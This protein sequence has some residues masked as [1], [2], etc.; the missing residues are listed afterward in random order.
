MVSKV[1]PTQWAHAY[2]APWL[3]PK[4]IEISQREITEAVFSVMD[5]DGLLK[6]YCFAFFIDGLDEFQSTVRDDH[7]DLVK[8]L[9]NWAASTSGNIKIC[10]SSREH[11]V[12]MDGFTSALRIRL[13]VLTRQDMDTYI[14]DKA[15]HASSQEG[16]ESLVTLIMNKAHG[17]FLW[18][19]LVVKSL[20][21]G[22]ENG[23]SC[24]HLTREADVLPEQMEKLYSHILNSMGGLSRRRAFQ[25][26]SR[27]MELKKYDDYSMSLLAYSFLE[28]YE[29]GNNS[30]IHGNDVFPMSSL[31]GDRGKERVRS[32]SRRL[33]GWCKG[34]VEPY[35]MENMVE[36]QEYENPCAVAWKDWAM[37][38]DFAHRSVLGFLELGRVV[39]DFQLV[40][41]GFDHADAI[42]NL[43]VSDILF[44]NTKS[45][46]TTHRSGSST[47]VLLGILEHYNINH[48]PYTYLERL[49]AL[50]IAGKHKESIFYSIEPMVLWRQREGLKTSGCVAMFVGDA[51][52]ELITSG[53]A[54]PEDEKRMLRSFFVSDPL[55][56][57]TW[58]GLCDYPLW[59]ISNNSELSK[60]SEIIA[61]LA[62]CCLVNGA[63]CW[64]RSNYQSSHVLETLLERGWL[65][66]D[67][68]TN[69]R[70]SDIIIPGPPHEHGDM[71]GFTLWQTF[72]V[73]TL[74][75]WYSWKEDKEQHTR[76]VRYQGRLFELFLRFR[77]DTELSFT[78]YLDR[79]TRGNSRWL[80]VEPESWPDNEIDLTSEDG[81]TPS[82]Q[83]SLREFVK[84]SPFDNK[85]IILQMLDEQSKLSTDIQTN[86]SSAKASIIRSGGCIGDEIALEGEEDPVDNASRR[87][88][89]QP[90]EDIGSPPASRWV[91]AL[92][93]NEFFR[94]S[95]A[96]LTGKS[97]SRGV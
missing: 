91:A 72:L 38:L 61:L 70:P 59:C 14:R 89:L 93:R 2:S 83:I 67:T 69:Y 95:M 58:L 52:R 13:H 76:A 50:L 74:S 47:A 45:L 22:L 17:V 15:E 34:L 28:D 12:F 26:F 40:L 39:L 48:E 55:H 53:V 29:N 49:R 37:E 42:L 73:Q 9:C 16:F 84:L 1:W 80:D 18:V 4:D 43:I 32:T 30:F 60:Q 31:T 75:E 63:R 62:S 66:P 88:T 8:L 78:I 57:L 64:G 97:L 10:V 71:S 85:D 6:N 41:R 56:V 27:V 23:M 36:V 54:S 96:A 20:R 94:L 24:T 87:V 82:L 33:A 46:Y 25:T 68:V 79:T 19:A 86:S 3:V 51:P 35:T 7:R 44:E 11:P 81:T 65:S 92:L 90:A 77:P 5:S 21:E